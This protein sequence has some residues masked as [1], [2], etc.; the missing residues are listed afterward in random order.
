MST[1]LSYGVRRGPD[2]GR[3]LGSGWFALLAVVTASGL[4]LK[5][6]AAASVFDLPLLMSGLCVTCFYVVLALLMLMRP[7]AKAQTPGWLPKIAA[8]LGTY[9]PWSV[10]FFGEITDVPVLNLL[11]I[12]C[13]VAGMVMTLVTIRHL[14]RSFSLAPQARSVVK[15]GPYRRIRHPLYLSEE[16]A[17]LGVVLQ[18]L[19][20]GTLL[21][22]AVHVAIQVCRIH[23]EE[24]L[25][26]RTLPDYDAYAA[27]RWRLIPCVW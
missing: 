26:G 2:L 27:S 14:G 1:A 4:R 6:E 9:M 12:V 15:T 17:I 22:L 8:L 13:I 19:S 21:V 3:L 18:Y 24:A 23:Y 16:I 20:L 5:L 10:S 25:L 11:A 7:P